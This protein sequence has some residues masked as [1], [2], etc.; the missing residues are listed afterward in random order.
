MA[1]PVLVAILALPDRSEAGLFSWLPHHAHRQQYP[2]LPPSVEGR[3]FAC[4]HRHHGTGCPPSAYT[5]CHYNTPALYRL[6]ADFHAPRA[7]IHAPDRYP[8][9]TPSYRIIPFPC[10]AV[11]PA[12]LYE[13][14]DLAR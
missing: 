4:L 3:P 12:T 11:T 14:R 5:P 13:Y 7:G 10:R 2:E 6:Y 8:G 9:V 1:L